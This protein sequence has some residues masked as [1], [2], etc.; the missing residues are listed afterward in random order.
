MTDELWN[1]VD[2]TLDQLTGQ[3]RQV[4]MLLRG[5]GRD[6]THDVPWTQREVADHLQ[7]SRLAVRQA[8]ARA[9]A[10]ISSAIAHHM[11]LKMFGHTD[12]LRR[13]MEAAPEGVSIDQLDLTQGLDGVPMSS[14]GQQP[15]MTGAERDAEATRRLGTDDPGDVGMAWEAFHQRHLKRGDQ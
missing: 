1:I 10:I 2:A 14:S 6:G 12:S 9:A 15:P 8:D 5:L 11:A 13:L 7:I 4:W 3:Q